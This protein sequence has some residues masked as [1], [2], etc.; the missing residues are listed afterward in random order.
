ML[1]FLM[2]QSET[3]IEM[4]GSRSRSHFEIQYRMWTLL[5]LDANNSNDF[6]EYGK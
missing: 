3:E 4:F 2:V 1:G 6:Q 5:L